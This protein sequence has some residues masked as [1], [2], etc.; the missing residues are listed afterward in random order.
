[1]F[2]ESDMGQDF[3]TLFDFFPERSP[4]LRNTFFQ[5]LYRL[6]MK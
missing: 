3:K 1:M 4:S 5:N 2:A 6:C